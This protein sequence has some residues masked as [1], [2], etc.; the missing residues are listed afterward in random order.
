MVWK[1]TASYHDQEMRPVSVAASALKTDL[2]DMAMR[3]VGAFNKDVFLCIMRDRVIV[4]L[5]K[6]SIWVYWSEEGNSRDSGGGGKGEVIGV[7]LVN[8]PGLAHVQV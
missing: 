6:S 5:S 7:V 3:A 2:A 1:W 4:A 8:P